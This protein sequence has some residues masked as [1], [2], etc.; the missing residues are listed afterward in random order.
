MK[1]IYERNGKK[2][3]ITEK[4]KALVIHWL[5]RN[6]EMLKVSLANTVVDEELLTYLDNHM[7]ELQEQK[8]IS[9]KN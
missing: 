7:K 9:L 2:V 1:F 4:D 8:E 3:L 5:I 6:T